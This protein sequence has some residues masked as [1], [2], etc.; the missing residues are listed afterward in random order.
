MRH[1]PWYRRAVTAALLAAL[2]P[3]GVAAAGTARPALAPGARGPAVAVLERRLA[4]LGYETGAVDGVF[5][6]ATSAGVAAFHKV[7]RLGAGGAVQPATWAALAR[8]AAPRPRYPTVRTA[9]EID[10]SRQVLYVVR[11]RAV[12]RVLNVSTGRAGW[13]TP[14]GRYQVQRRI[15]GWRRSPLGLMWRPNYFYR[16]YAVHGSYSVPRYPASHGCVRVTIPAMNWLWSQIGIG[17]PVAVYRSE[18]GR[19]GMDPGRAG[20]EP[21]GAQAPRRAPSAKQ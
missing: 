3:A 21:T 15:N 7:N 5:D 12:A 10:L 16:G 1:A 18:V 13:R 19:A 4:E 17:T 2:A 8:P 6:A 14:T 20:Q 9:V 11:N